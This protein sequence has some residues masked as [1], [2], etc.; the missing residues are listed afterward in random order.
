[1][2]WEWVV[3]LLGLAWLVVAIF[4]IAALSNKWQKIE[5]Q[6]DIA[7]YGSE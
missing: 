7:R 3:L 2:T 4:A 5:Q 6:R 1:M